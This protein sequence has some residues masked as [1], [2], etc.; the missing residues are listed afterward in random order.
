MVD[1]V[2]HQIFRRVNRQGKGETRVVGG[3]V[4]EVSDERVKVEIAPGLEPVWVR[5]D[6]VTAE[7][8][9]VDVSVGTDGRPLGAAVTGRIPFGAVLK[10]VGATG[11]TILG[12]GIKID[13]TIQELAEARAR[14]EGM[15]L[16]IVTA[17]QFLPVSEVAPTL[18]DDGHPVGSIWRQV[19]ET[20]AVVAKW[21]YTAEGW[22]P[23]TGA[24]I[25]GE[26]I[27]AA[28]GV[29]IDAM[30]ENLTVTGAANITEA[31]I[32]ELTARI[33]SI[34]T[35]N[36][37]QVVIGRDARFTSGGLV[38]YAPPAQGQ[39]PE[40][41]ANRTPIIALT[42]TG[43]VAISVAKN[44]KITAGMTPDGDVWG[45]T[46]KFD[47]LAVGGRDLAAI[48]A[49]YA[50]GSRGMTRINQHVDITNVV[51]HVA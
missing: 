10:H 20:G 7:N 4:V 11:A 46:G 39:D 40:D 50:L 37:E 27:A 36:A 33:A 23:F 44:G 51:N 24:V 22:A 21:V 17:G 29:F 14:L 19:D 43:D 5:A 2:T 34:L 47:A 16:A 1:D 26:T 8:A 12:Q 3:R 42:P 30:M 41:W 38:F 48:L 35:L 15:D 32:G 9:Q 18:E 13:Q 49:Q 31:A 6:G 45:K 25:Q 28:V